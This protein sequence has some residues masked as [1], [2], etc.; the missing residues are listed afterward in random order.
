MDRQK[1]TCPLTYFA[2]GAQAHRKPAI[3]LDSA[4]TK[5]VLPQGRFK[6]GNKTLATMIG[7]TNIPLNQ[8]GKDIYVE[9]ATEGATAISQGNNEFFRAD[10]EF[11]AA[12]AD[13]RA[14]RARLHRVGNLVRHATGTASE[15]D[16]DELE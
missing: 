5:K 12:C 16:K 8:E 13:E 15:C 10:D 2:I 3:L 6:I 1:V 9:E 14:S 11:E 7:K 4:H